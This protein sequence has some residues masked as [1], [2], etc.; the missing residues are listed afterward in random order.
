M[1]ISEAFRVL[2]V[3]C[4]KVLKGPEYTA[5][6]GYHSDSLST[7]PVTYDSV[8]V[9]VYICSYPNAMNAF[10][11]RIENSISYIMYI[12]SPLYILW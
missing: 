6:F 8:T 7:Y 11:F 12:C 5:N 9:S 10:T 3:P 2:S 1:Q 4:K